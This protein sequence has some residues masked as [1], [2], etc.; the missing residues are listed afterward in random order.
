MFD[1]PH[2]GINAY[3]KKLCAPGLECRQKK[4]RHGMMISGCT[5]YCLRPERK[6]ATGYVPAKE[7]KIFLLNGMMCADPRKGAAP[8]RNKQ[9]APGLECRQ[10]ADRHGMIASG[11]SSYCQKP[12]G[13]LRKHKPTFDLDGLGI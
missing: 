11:S 13:A 9:C 2:R 6:Q 4:D 1:V 7:G 12:R 5:S 10:K 3:R 8:F